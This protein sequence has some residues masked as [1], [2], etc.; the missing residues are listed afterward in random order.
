MEFKNFS[1]FRVKTLAHGTNHEFTKYRIGISNV[2]R[3]VDVAG[4]DYG[5]FSLQVIVNNPG[6]NDDG[7]ILENYDSLK[8]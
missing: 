8:S 1:L 6:Q 7:I 5:S 4:S 3:A 2:K